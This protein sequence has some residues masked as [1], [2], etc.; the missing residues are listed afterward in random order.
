MGVGARNI[1]PVEHE[2]DMVRTES[3]FSWSWSTALEAAV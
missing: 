2:A 3:K 1:H